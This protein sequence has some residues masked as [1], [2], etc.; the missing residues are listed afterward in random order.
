MIPGENLK[1]ITSL[2]KSE[3]P[4]KLYCLRFSFFHAFVCNN[5]SQFVGKFRDICMKYIL[6]AIPHL[7]VWSEKNFLF[8]FFSL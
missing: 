7:Q 3:K 4:Q 1:E 8:G 5:K 6:S 2:E